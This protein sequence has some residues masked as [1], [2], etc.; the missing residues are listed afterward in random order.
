MSDGISIVIPAR[1]EAETVGSVVA[2]VINL[3][4]VR[5]VVVV[6]TDSWDST[7]ANAA[8]AGAVVVPEPR[9]GMGRALKTGYKAAKSSWVMKLDADLDTFDPGMVVVL[10]ESREPNVGMV[11]GNWQDPNDDMPMTRLLVRPAIRQIFPGLQHITAVNSGIY[12]FNRDLI[13][14]DALVDN[15][16]ADIDVMLRVHAADHEVIE[17][18]IGQI[19]HDP[20][21]KEHYNAMAD[22]ILHLFLQHY[23]HKINA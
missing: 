1:N 2:A 11:K 17:V 10:A 14:I 3:P 13:E 12:L 22:N 19:S 5:E 23:A 4:C 16:A 20:R 8:A 7:A 6:D 18:A 21:N 15:N 9:L